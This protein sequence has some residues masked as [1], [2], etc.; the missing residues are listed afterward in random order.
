MTYRTEGER[1][2]AC[3]RAL[4]GDIAA[5]GCTRL[6][7]ERDESLVRADKQTLIEAMHA[8][9]YHNFEYVHDKAHGQPLLAIPD[10]I[11]WAWAAG[12]DWLQ[13]CRSITTCTDI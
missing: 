10:A 8:T 12:G 9:D 7:L 4:V 3:L 1:R 13:A 11:A 6:V 2:R 5:S